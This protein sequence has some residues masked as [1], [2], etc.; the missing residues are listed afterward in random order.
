M[1]VFNNTSSELPESQIEYHDGDGGRRIVTLII[2]IVLA[3][4]VATLV[5]F[6]GRWVYHKVSN[7]SGPT[8]TTIA[9]QGTKQGSISTNTSPASPSPNSSNPQT[10]AP[11]PSQTGKSPTTYSNPSPTPP[12]NSSGSQSN[13]KSNPAPAPTPTPTSL[14]NNGPGEVVALFAG[15][16]LVAGT[17]HFIAASRKLAKDS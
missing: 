15:T 7:N 3:L 12:P 8:P 6:A 2:Y 9:P 11:S 13:G 5:V 14:P 4:A 1:A 16:S 17:M 10:P